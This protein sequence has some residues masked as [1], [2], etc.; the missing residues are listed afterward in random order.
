M[1]DEHHRRLEEFF[2]AARERPVAE[3]ACGDDREVLSLLAYD[4]DDTPAPGTRTFEFAPPPGG[5]GPGMILA[6]RYRVVGVLGRGGM[7]EV[8]RAEDLKLGQAVALKFLP[9]AVRDDP[10]RLALLFDEVRTART[11]SKSQR[12]AGLRRRRGR[13]RAL[14]VDGVH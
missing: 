4:P 14:P 5:F 11:I 12:L 7:G 3:R 8:Y 1:S 13:R 10:E 6:G 2:A 9:A